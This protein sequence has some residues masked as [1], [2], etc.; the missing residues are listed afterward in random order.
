MA[1]ISTGVLV[2]GATRV[3]TAA[4]L[5]RW[6]A[7]DVPGTALA[8]PVFTGMVIAWTMAGIGLGLLFAA[9]GGADESPV[10]GIENLAYA[11]FIAGLALVPAPLMLVLSRRHLWLVAGGAVTFAAIF[12]VLMPYLA[13]R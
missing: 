4:W 7:R 12:G 1:I 6:V 2:A 10:P 8:V 5:D 9:L 3:R 13:A 11:V